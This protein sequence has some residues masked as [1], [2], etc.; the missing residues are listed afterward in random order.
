MEIVGLLKILL[1]VLTKVTSVKSIFV[2]LAI[3]A[4]FNVIGVQSRKHHLEVQ[5][6]NNLCK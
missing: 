5:V 3:A 6:R 1:A 4:Y 2:S